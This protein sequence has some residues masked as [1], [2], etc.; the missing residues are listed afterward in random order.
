MFL[1]A[2]IATPVSF[3]QCVDVMKSVIHD[4]RTERKNHEGDLQKKQVWC[5]TLSSVLVVGACSAA[6]HN[7]LT[8][9]FSQQ[10]QRILAGVR[11]KYESA[12]K[13]YEKA[14]K[15]VADAKGKLEKV[16]SAK[17][18]SRS[19]IDKVRLDARFANHPP[20]TGNCQ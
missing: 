1:F 19:K 16:Q 20:F 3:Y 14:T 8:T 7:M 13:L 10:C 18:T 6:Y 9:S 2:P 17:D 15:E 5:A 4:Q 12:R 11:S